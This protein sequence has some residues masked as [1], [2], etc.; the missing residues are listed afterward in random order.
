[1]TEDQKIRLICGVISAINSNKKQSGDK[2]P[3]MLPLEE[4]K[5]AA[6]HL[7][8]TQVQGVLDELDEFWKG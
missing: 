2:S 4:I 1:M 8:H 6:N 3:L 7:E 5:A